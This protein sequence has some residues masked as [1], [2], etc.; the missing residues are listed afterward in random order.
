[1]RELGGGL[2]EEKIAPLA[3]RIDELMRHQRLQLGEAAARLRFPALAARPVGAA[4]QVAAAA[5]LQRKKLWFQYCSRTDDVQSDR[6]VSPQRLTHYRE[7]WYLDAWDESKDALRTFSVDRIT[8]PCVLE[9]RAFDVLENEL[10]EHYTT[11]YGI[12]GGKADKV[13][14]LRFTKERA[15]WV[16]D[17]LG[18]LS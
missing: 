18:T 11:S 9:E 7:S 17:G 2:L 16:A 13:A 12:F 14:V 4:F 5:T 6:Q 3:K 1:M 8:R 15:R 10:D